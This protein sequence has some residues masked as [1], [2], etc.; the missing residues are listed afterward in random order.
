MADVI[1]R[2]ERG[3]LWV[4]V[5]V[6]YDKDEEATA[7][8]LRL[9]RLGRAAEIGF[10]RMIHNDCEGKEQTDWDGCKVCWYREFCRERSGNNAG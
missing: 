4:G 6:L 3:E 2:I 10:K 5:G 8:L 7:E 9:A 1:E